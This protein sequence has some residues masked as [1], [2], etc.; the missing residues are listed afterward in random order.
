M[1]KLS[2]VSA[3]ILVLLSTSMVLA[4]TL[5]DTGQTKCYDNSGEIACPSPGQPFYGQY[6]EAMIDNLII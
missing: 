6:A 1:K 4:G 5:P 3:V 2:I